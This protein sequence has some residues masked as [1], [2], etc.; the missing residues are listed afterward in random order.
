MR[1]AVDRDSSR[2]DFWN[3]L[4]TAYGGGGKMAEAERA[5]AEAA[6]RDNGNAMFRYNHALAL[7]QLGRRDEALAELRAA[8]RLGSSEAR[9][10]VGTR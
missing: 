3:A 5:F 1:A 10:L 6:A 4:G 7:Q 9:A 8:A 2:A